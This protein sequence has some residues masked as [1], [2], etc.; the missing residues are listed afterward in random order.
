MAAVITLRSTRFYNSNFF[1]NF[2]HLLF[3]LLRPHHLSLYPAARVYLDFLS[4]KT[5][6]GTER[7]LFPIIPAGSAD[8]GRGPRSQ[9][10]A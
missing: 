7:D 1:H 5:P 4:K 9:A 8:T 3:L 10:G 6:K 2:R